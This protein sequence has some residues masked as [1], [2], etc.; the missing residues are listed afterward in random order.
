MQRLSSQLKNF[1]GV[2]ICFSTLYVPFLQKIQI[3]HPEKVWQYGRGIIQD[4]DWVGPNLFLAAST[5]LWVYDPAAD[6]SLSKLT[7]ISTA[8]SNKVEVGDG[9]T[10]QLLS[11]RT[12]THFISVDA[13]AILR[14]RDA[15]TGAVLARFPQK[16]NPE[17]FTWESSGVLIARTEYDSSA[18]EEYKY[19][20][21]LW[22]TST[23]KQVGVVGRY[24]RSVVQ[25]SW[26]PLG[27]LLAV[28]LDDGTVIIED[29]KQG[30]QIRKLVAASAVTT[31]LEWSPDGTRL[32]AG[33]NRASPVTV[34]RTDTFDELVAANPPN[35]I[36]NLS[37]NADSKRLVGASPDGVAIWNIETGQLELL[38]S[39]S[40]T[41]L[42]Y[43]VQRLAWHD[44][45]VAILDWT[46]QLFT[47]NTRTGNLKGIELGFT[48]DI[49]SL[50][51]SHDGKTVA[52][53]YRS[54]DYIVLLDGT[55]GTFKQSLHTGLNTQLAVSD[56]AWD[57][58][59]QY[60][61]IGNVSTLYIWH[62]QLGAQ[63]Q[64]RTI[65]EIYQPRFSW[66]PNSV[67]AVV[68][69][70]YQQEELQFIDVKASDQVIRRQQLPGL[71]SV[72]WS[73]DGRWLAM[74][75]H[76][77]DREV[78]AL[79]QQQVD[80]W[81]M[82]Q[83]T[84]ATVDLPFAGLTRMA[85]EEYFV[86]KPD[87]SQ[88]IGFT[89]GAKLLWRWQVGTQEAS[90][91]AAGP[92]SNQAEQAIPLTINGRGDLLATLA[93]GNVQFLDANSGQQ[94]SLLSGFATAS[95]FFGW[96]GDD[97]FVIYDSTVQAFQVKH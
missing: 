89:A 42:N 77:R 56:M 8:S 85:P 35:L 51:V 41:H 75:R 78:V 2:L 53:A 52:L 18:P 10:T 46:K 70:M 28:R 88:L 79:P 30:K 6:N 13:D 12:G 40:R 26:H 82:L 34:W 54:T 31:S 24:S 7:A 49:Q 65:N 83:N 44:D 22:N 90:V 68:S 48:G 91:F 94:L 97:Q 15:Q 76:Y 1:L 37:W 71:S 80:M 43:P 81:D 36:T 14:V 64:L 60:L 17:Y 72:S 33:G 55:N 3:V 96:S 86:W 47:W 38:S 69:T 59:D 9:W 29:V 84:S 67:L 23:G 92:G 74:Y 19:Q 16:S 39:E 61:A 45:Q 66:S 11:N 21:A 95:P 87:S 32:A 58:T 57:A 4:F 25:L 93:F 62:L 73:P 27:D 20:V 5:G 50:A 63:A